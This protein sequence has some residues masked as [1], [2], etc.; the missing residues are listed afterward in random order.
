MSEEILK[1]LM[2][3]F[4]IVSKQDGLVSEL[5][6][7]RVETFLKQQISPN[8]VSEYLAFFDKESG[9]DEQKKLTDL[10]EKP[11]LTS[12][13]DSVKTLGICRKINKTLEQKQKIVVFVRI[14]EMIWADKNISPLAMELIE[15]VAS[16]FKIED[17]EYLDLQKFVFE[18]KE[19]FEKSQHILRVD[20]VKAKQVGRKQVV[21]EDNKHIY[22]ENFVGE[23]LFLKVNSVELYF[24]KSNSKNLYLNGLPIS[25]GSVNIFPSGSTLKM[26]TGKPL[27]Y[28][29]ISSR[30]LKDQLDVNISFNAKEV[31]YVFPNGRIGLHNIN[32]SE[33]TGKLVGIMG[34]S[35]AGK[36]T[37][38]NVLNGIDA[39][40]SGRVLINGIDIHKE[41]DK[42]EGVIG[43]VPQDDLLIDELTV[44]ENLFYSGKLCL[45]NLTDEQLHERIINLLKSLDLLMTKDLK[46][47]NPL[48]KTISGGQRKRLNIGLELLREPSV[49]FVDEPTS[50]LSS[51]DSDNIM[52]LLKELT[53]KGKIIFVVIHQPSSDIYKMFD[54]MFILDVGGYTVYYGNPVEALLYFKKKS[55]QVDQ[56]SGECVSCGNVN[57]EL[58]FNIIDAKLVDDY[59]R[60]LDQRKVTPIQ[61][62]QY[63]E[64]EIK[65]DIVEDATD[66][67]P[68]SLFI[69]TKI[70][71][72]WTFVQRDIL[73]KLKNMQYVLINTLEAPALA[74]VLATIVKN[75][76]DSVNYNFFKNDNVP[77]YIF[78]SIVVAMFMGLTISAEEIIK[79][80]RIL[81]REQFLNLSKLS[82]LFS[83]FAI[84][85]SISAFQTLLYVLVGNSILDIQGMT[86]EYWLVLF[87]TACFANILGLNISA[88]F[89]SAATIYILIPLI[90]IPQMIL[91]GAMFSF[92][93]INKIF[94]G[95]NRVPMIAESMVSRWAFEALEVEQFKANDFNK[96]L[97][98]WNKLESDLN[99]RLAY[100]IP[101]IRERL[102]ECN[103]LKYDTSDDAIEPFANNLSAI[104]YAIEDENLRLAE[105][106]R[107]LETSLITPKNYN[108]EVGKKV[109]EHVNYLYDYYN[110]FFVEISSHLDGKKE[111][112]MAQKGKLNY[113]YLKDNYDNESLNNLVKNANHMNKIKILNGR[114]EQI[115]DPVYKTPERTSGIR[116][117]FF[118]SIKPIPGTPFFASTF[119]VNIAVIWLMSVF[120][121]VALYYDGLKKLIDRL[122]EVDWKNLSKPVLKW[123]VKVLKFKITILKLIYEYVIKGF[124]KYV[125]LGFYKYV[126][127]LIFIT[128]VLW[129]F[130]GI[131][132]IVL[133]FTS[134]FKSN[135]KPAP[136]ATVKADSTAEKPAE[137]KKEEKD[138]K[139]SNDIK[140]ENKE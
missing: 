55:N 13:N 51:R 45:S 4:A 100:L 75:A 15:T 81:K 32:I 65:Y 136:K 57:P 5:Q 103:Q 58:V 39:P 131:G 96:D 112:L 16:V 25:E 6:R 24:L 135:K 30:F 41:K 133:G 86:F 12:V 73:S 63:F 47:G 120:C 36:S 98:F 123:V 42:I 89:N 3:L 97:F 113:Q 60:H 139:E 28:S 19:H 94:G 54:K 108:E 127:K 126:I 125:I 105:E 91:S 87:S 114:F 8:Q 61:W 84:L 80:R 35:G 116:A 101:E 95:E 138:N 62:N 90:L 115:I 31:K 23:V 74:F 79:D 40:T 107:F 44:Y 117:H 83:K 11:R 124:Y 78:M 7:A 102:N 92:D 37:L 140:N 104:R 64:N 53:L 27:Y 106:H 43:Y 21:K 132:K 119:A 52:D 56:D 99:Y 128:P 130:G 134:I 38:L 129:F 109:K 48:E 17:E 46:V 71:Q 18:D 14:L 10:D 82:Y 33:E 50:G 29:E 121:A 88:S 68:N 9:Y 59:G 70:K 85:F 22:Y 69:P 93:K 110:E 26:P 67:P 122:S 137:E 1:A 76:T 66:Q 111:N 34:A 2:Q 77:A 20:G 118:S 49:M 72:W